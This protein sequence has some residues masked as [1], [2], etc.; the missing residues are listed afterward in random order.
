[1]QNVPLFFFKKKKIEVYNIVLISAVQPSDLAC[2]LF[3]LLFCDGLS[4]DIEYSSLC[5]RV[6]PC[7][8]SVLYIIA[9]SASPKLPILPSECSFLKSLVF[10]G[11]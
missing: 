6:G 4:Q 3:H 1:M 11:I 10:R 7:C 2:T 9:A 5:S 8:L